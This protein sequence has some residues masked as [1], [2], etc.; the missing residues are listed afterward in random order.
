[1]TELKSFL[2]VCNL[3]RRFV[4][5][6]ARIAALLNRKSEKGPTFHFGKLNETKI[7]ALET[8]QYR[9]LSP[10]ILALLRPNGRYTLDTDVCDKQAE[11]VLLQEEP[12]DQQY[13]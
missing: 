12:K 10:P 1:M 4:P 9:L 11:C 3:F 8:L 5:N 13:P 7:E 2:G 6:F